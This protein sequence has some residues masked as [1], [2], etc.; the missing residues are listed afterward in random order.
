MLVGLWVMF[1]GMLTCSYPHV[2]G[3]WYSLLC[4]EWPTS[5]ARA[6]VYCF[7]VV[8]FFSFFF[9]FFFCLCVCYFS[10]AKYPVI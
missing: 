1:A 9:L 2:L 7:F 6:G 4:I 3:K 10:L 5:T 8:F